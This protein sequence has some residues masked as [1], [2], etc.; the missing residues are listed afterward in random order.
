MSAVLS[1]KAL[2]GWD[3]YDP[4]GNKV[5]RICDLV[6]SADLA[7]VDYVVLD[8]DRDSRPADTWL[9]ISPQMLLLD[10]ENECFVAAA[11]EHLRTFTYKN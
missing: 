5:G 2:K 11:D 9:A 4:S 1:S 10:T 3:V 8:A 7:A 6:I